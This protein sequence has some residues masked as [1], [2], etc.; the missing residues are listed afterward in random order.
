MKHPKPGGTVA[1][2]ARMNNQQQVTKRRRR[3]GPKVT[4]DASIQTRFEAFH[5]ANPEVYEVLVRMARRLKASGRASYSIAGIYE[6]CRYDRYVTTKGES[7]K[8]ENNFRSRY[9]RL[10]MEKESDLAGFFVV[11]PLRA[12]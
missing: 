5:A 4:A 9:A 2:A 11:R 10:I 7:F 1:E 3:L 6:V 8:L 12:L